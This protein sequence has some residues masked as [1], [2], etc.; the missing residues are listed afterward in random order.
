MPLILITAVIVMGV[1]YMLLVIVKLYQLRYYF[2]HSVSFGDFFGQNYL[3]V[4]ASGTRLMAIWVLAFHLYHY[5][6]MEITTAKE[7]ARL[8]VVARDAQLHQLS[9]QL[10]PHFFFN[11]LNSVKALIGTQPEKARRAIDLLSDLLRNSL[12]GNNTGLIPLADEMSLVNDYLEL[13]KI[14][15]EE[16]LQFNVAIDADLQRLLVLPLSIQ[17]LVENAL[18]HG[19]AQQKNGGLVN[20]TVQ[21]LDAG[22]NISIQNPGK[23]IAGAGIGG[24]GLKNLEERL[25]LQYASKASFKLSE[26]PGNK[27]LATI[28]I[29]EL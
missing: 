13:E 10:N 25:L 20:I 1:V 12:Y 5:A 8:Q 9:S 4:L 28:I 24:L 17:T 6:L 23:L 11:S 29:P 3:V 18:K 26:L 22:I 14:R 7:Y 27:V 19:I 2:D 21:K 15:F 16:R